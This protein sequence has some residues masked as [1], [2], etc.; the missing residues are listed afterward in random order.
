MATL[1]ALATLEPF[2]L[3]SRTLLGRSP[4]AQLRLHDSCVS[5]EHAL[6]SWNGREWLAQDLGSRNGT[7]LDDQRLPP[8]VRAPL[9]I[10]AVLTLGHA[11]C[12]L[13]LRD[14]APPQVLALPEDGGAARCGDPELLALPSPEQPLVTVYRDRGGQWLLEREGASAPVADGASVQ[15]GGLRF[16]V[17]LPELLPSTRED[18]PPQQ[19]A[20]RE[21]HLRV[22]ADEE[23]IEAS[24]HT[25]AGASAQTLPLGARAHNAL[26]LVLARERLRD[27][28]RGVAP[29][30]QGWLHMEDLCRQLRLDESHI[31]VMVFRCRQQL[32]AVGVPG[33]AELIERRKP[34]RQLRVG[35]ARLQVLPP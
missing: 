17:H 33:A 16:T 7:L 9:R 19:P 20:P 21:L 26:L 31:N 8:G 13:R 24:L 22:S 35:V 30:E 11:R 25:V 15:A 27:Q 6:V 4:L 23:F 5:A 10:G 3:C 2:P 32:A 1:E 14:A 34:T 18:E 29:G 12:R 28:A